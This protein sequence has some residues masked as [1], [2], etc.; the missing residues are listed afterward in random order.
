MLALEASSTCLRFRRH[1]A[2]L[3]I[4]HRH[5]GVLHWRNPMFCRGT[6]WAIYVV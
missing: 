2:T 4:Y 1:F 3:S 5:V 6:W